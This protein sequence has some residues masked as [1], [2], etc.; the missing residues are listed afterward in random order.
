M[1]KGYELDGHI[2][3]LKRNLY[4]MSEAPMNF[5]NHLKQQ[6]EKRGFQAS[7]YDPCLFMNHKTGCIMLTYV[8]DCILFHRNEKVIDST[9][10]SLQNTKSGELAT[11][12]IQVESDYAGFLG[13]DI[14]KRD[15]GTLELKQTG[16]IQRILRALNLHSD[17]VTTRLEPASKEPLGKDENGPPR[18]ESWSYPSLIGMLLYLSGNSRPEL[19]FAVNQCARFNH[20]PRLRH[21]QAV[22]RIARYLKGTS[23]NGMI[24]NPNKDLQLEMFADAD[25]AGLW[26]FENKDDPT[27]VKSRSGILITLGGVP[28]FWSSKLQTEIATS[29]MHAE[30]IALSTGMRELVSIK[31]ITDDLCEHL[32]I[33][34]DQETKINQS[35]TKIIEPALK[36]ANSPLQRHTP[37]SKHFAITHYHWFREKLEDLDDK[38]PT[39]RNKITKGRYSNQRFTR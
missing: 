9:I 30:Y 31:G 15:D 26:G 8:D 20:C 13:I 32:D 24:I 12:L 18:Q 10:D 1:P 16:L 22:K 23:Q 19:T 7:A 35:N 25:F 27:C 4:G 5:F 3:E 37:Q 34:R 17:D 11:F 29:T 39:Y 21:E 14:H 28:L 38:N 36:L 6:L 2:L 33:I